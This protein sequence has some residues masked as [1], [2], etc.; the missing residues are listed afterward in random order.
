MFVQQRGVS[1][2]H[3]EIRLC[4]NELEPPAGSARRVDATECETAENE[5][6]FTG[7]LGL[8]GALSKLIEQAPD[9]LDDVD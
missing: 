7:W 6:V 1:I 5:V 8:L 4:L 3:M 9:G 2:D